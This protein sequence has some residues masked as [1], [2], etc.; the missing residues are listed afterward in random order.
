MPCLR[1]LALRE[2]DRVMVALLSNFDEP[3]VVGV[4]DGFTPRPEPR[5]TASHV[6][7]LKA[8]ERLRVHASDGTALIEIE[9]TA[10]GPVVNLL[11]SDLALRVPGT[12]TLDAEAIELR[13]RRG[14]VGITASDDVEINGELIRLNSSEEAG[15]VVSKGE[16]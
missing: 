10:Q 8:D 14:P 3:V 15:G 16:P 12:L 2:G 5:V 13:A 4:L 1:A 6:I 9:P 7:E 11:S